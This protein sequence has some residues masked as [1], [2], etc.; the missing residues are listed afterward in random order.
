MNPVSELE[1]TP[2][3]LSEKT[4]QWMRLYFAQQDQS[5]A[6]IITATPNETS[7]DLMTVVQWKE[8]IDWIVWFVNIALVCCEH[9]KPMKEANGFFESIMQ[10]FN[11]LAAQ[12]LPEFVLHMIFPISRNLFRFKQYHS[13]IIQNNLGISQ[14][15]II[16]KAEVLYNDLLAILSCIA[17]N[18]YV[19]ISQLRCEIPPHINTDVRMT[20]LLMQWLCSQAYLDR[21]ADSA[22]IKKAYDSIKDRAN[23]LIQAF[24][25]RA[26]PSPKLQRN[27]IFSIKHSISRNHL[28]FPVAPHLKPYFLLSVK[29]F[30][31]NRFGK[32]ITHADVGKFINFSTL[33]TLPAPPLQRV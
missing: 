20:I 24:F 13:D 28:S 8:I 6:T 3:N 5:I 29:C 27:R 10:L 11:N 26:F 17:N 12:K 21:R 19:P 14:G 18:T 2:P 23:P 7:T 1:F 9:N 32:E 30:L 33:C 22:N 4:F 25:L 15:D 16:S 31:E